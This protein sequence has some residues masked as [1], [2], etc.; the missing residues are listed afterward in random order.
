VWSLKHKVPFTV[1]E[2]F[3]TIESAR[4]H[5]ADELLGAYRLQ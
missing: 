4:L 5:D 1:L 3:F 2:K